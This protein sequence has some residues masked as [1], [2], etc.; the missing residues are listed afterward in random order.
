MKKIYILIC[1]IY[2]K[3]FTYIENIYLSKTIKKIDQSDLSKKGL[4]IIKLNYNFL[5]K[6][7]ETT[8]NINNY[9]T[10]DIIKF[11]DISL[12]I[13]SIFTDLKLKDTITNKTGF[14]YSIDYLISYTTYKIP[15]LDKKKEIYANDNSV[16]RRTNSNHRYLAIQTTK[17]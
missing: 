7:F 6:R 8:I 10:K 17:G 2:C 13:D 5:P 3:L 12:L 11:S 4:E 9:M 15:E 1:A 16:N 14:K